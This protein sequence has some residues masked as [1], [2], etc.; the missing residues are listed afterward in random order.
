MI[1]VTS[2][3]EKLGRVPEGEILIPLSWMLE[4]VAMD[5]ITLWGYFIFTKHYFSKKLLK[6]FIHFSSSGLLI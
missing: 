6:S 2:N 5:K 3:E 1:S 4:P